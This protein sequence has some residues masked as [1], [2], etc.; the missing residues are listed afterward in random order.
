VGIRL[1]A[2]WMMIMENEELKRS[3][4]YYVMLYTREGLKNAGK[5]CGETYI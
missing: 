5:N 3:K 1:S 4:M 2:D